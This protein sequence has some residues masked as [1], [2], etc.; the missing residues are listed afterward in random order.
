MKRIY[1]DMD[2]VLC[3]YD[4]SYAIQKVTNIS[5]KYPQSILGFYE[6]LVP[7]YGAVEAFNTLSKNYDV[8][9][10]TRPSV[11]NLHC[12][13]EKAI[14][15]KKYLGEKA[16]DKLIISCDKSLLRG[17]YLIDDQ[18]G[19]GQEEFEGELIRFGKHPYNN[20]EK[21]TNYLINKTTI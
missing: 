4:A 12:Y 7:L 5:I 20:W 1:I 10:L 17:D 13:T 18:V 3:D 9:I 21:V 19:F 15:V 6:N 2:G 14:W 8:W 16:L 11:K